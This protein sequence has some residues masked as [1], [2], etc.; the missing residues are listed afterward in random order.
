MS[1]PDSTG[2]GGRP[3]EIV[4]ALV[5]D[6]TFIAFSSAVE[7]LRMANRMSGERLYRWRIVSA[8][9]KPAVGSNGLS[10]Q[11]DGD[12]ESVGSADLVI[13]CSGEHVRRHAGKTYLAWLRRL[14]QRRI[15]L[16]AICT[17][18]YLLARADLLGGYRC[19]IHWEDL[20]SLRE[21]FPGVTITSELFEIDRDRYTCSGGVAPLDMM[22]NLIGDEHGSTLAVSISEEFICERIRGGNDRQR[23]P[24]MHHVGAGQPK[25]VEAISL[26]EA[27]IEEPMRLDEL[28]RHVGLS[29]RQLERLFRKHLQCVPARYYLELRLARA[30]RLLLQTTLSVVDV[31]FACGFV[32]APHFSKCYRDYYG[33]PPREERRLDRLPGGVAGRTRR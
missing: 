13:V 22:L 24:L 25:L 15:P 30:R 20:A 16:G 9:G 1:K 8:D 7:P 5:P 17:G 10:V 28:S 33:V 32:S 3:R 6:Y 21:E 26:M 14:A 4:F 29:R 23:I 2:P 19:T 18:A 11:V 12:L 27:N 31:A